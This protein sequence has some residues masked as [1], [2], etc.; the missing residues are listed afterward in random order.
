M[1][2]VLHFIDARVEVVVLGGQAGKVH[3]VLEKFVH[4]GVIIREFAFQGVVFE[5][6]GKAPC[7]TEAAAR[8]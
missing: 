4:R 7:K 3:V 1:P 2:A 6:H 5:R 8:G